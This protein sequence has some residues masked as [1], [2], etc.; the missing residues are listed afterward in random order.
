MRELTSLEIDMVS[1]GDGGDI[2]VV[3]PHYGSLD[4]NTSGPNKIMIAQAIASQN[5]EK[6][7]SKHAVNN[8]SNH[9]ADVD[10]ALNGIKSA[11]TS[12]MGSEVYSPKNITL[13][14]GSVLH[15][16]EIVDYLSRLQFEAV[17]TVFGNGRAGANT[18]GA[19]GL[20]HVQINVDQLLTYSG[21]P[22]NQGLN[23]L[24]FHEIAHDTP[25]GRA[26]NDAMWQ[27]YL[28]QPGVSDMTE[29]QKAQN[30]SNSLEFVTNEKW[31]NTDGQLMATALNMKDIPNPTY[32]F[33]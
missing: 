17:D 15:A 14:D 29:A 25:S 20:I 4:P 12:A 5:L 28:Q 8:S 23:Y 22:N 13:S 21:M 16:G 26:E 32:G 33:K 9:S 10:K 6:N 2:V 31:A 30:Y 18:I 3:G 11:L 19:D 1:G 27:H 7:H 24:V